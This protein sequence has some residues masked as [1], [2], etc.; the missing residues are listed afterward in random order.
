[1]KTFAVACTLATLLSAT[2]F[3]QASGDA[4]GASALGSG[5]GTPGTNSS[6]TAVPSGSGRG[7]SSATSTGH[8]AVDKADRDLDRK[9]KS[10]CKGC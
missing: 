5:A 7:G 3:G 9:I 4:G 6:G 10:I 8:K 2:A 1:M